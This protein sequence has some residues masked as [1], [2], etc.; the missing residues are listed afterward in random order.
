MKL[1]I[2]EGCPY[3]LKVRDAMKKFGLKE[4][5]DIELVDAHQEQNKK[6]LLELGG[7]AQVPFLVDN[8]V[9]MYESDEI[10]SYLIKKKSKQ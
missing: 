7:K 10:I 9:M 2:Y 6:K 3:C 5:V 8:E 1:F 4:E